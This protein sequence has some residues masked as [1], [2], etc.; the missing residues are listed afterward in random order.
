[1]TAQD[2]L[3]DVETATL[4]H[5]LESGFMAP[6]LQALLPERRIFGPALTV[7]MPGD[8]GS[9]LVEALSRAEPGQVIVIDR[10]GDLRADDVDRSVTLCGW[11]DRRREHGEHLAFIDLRDR[12]GVVQ[13]VIDGA[14]DLRSEY[15]LQVTGNVRLR[16]NDAANQ[17]LPTGA[18]EID[19]A[20]SLT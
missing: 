18:I 12:S 13:L 9:I 8:D 14:H 3:S 11:V 19:V 4:G 1:M 2:D 17:A 6:A 10:C 5:F 20:V 16:P 15:V 7:R